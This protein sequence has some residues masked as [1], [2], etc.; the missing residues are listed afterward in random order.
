[1]SLALQRR[2]LRSLTRITYLCK[3]IGLCLPPCCNTNDVGSSLSYLALQQHYP[4]SL[5]R[6]TDLSL[7]L[8]K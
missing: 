5:T 1:M 3:L 8:Y 6:I 7:T 2:Y 4:R